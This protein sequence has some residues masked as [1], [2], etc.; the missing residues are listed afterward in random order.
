MHIFLYFRFIVF[1]G[2]FWSIKIFRFS[3][4]SYWVLD[5][6]DLYICMYLA[7]VSICDFNVFKIVYLSLSRK[8]NIVPANIVRQLKMDFKG[9]ANIIRSIKKKFSVS[10]IKL[11]KIVFIN[12]THLILFISETWH[13]GLILKSNS[14]STHKIT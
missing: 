9:D 8:Q 1:L 10:K 5:T 13:N 14:Y 12:N 3:V 11:A 6:V 7:Y 4:Q 2:R